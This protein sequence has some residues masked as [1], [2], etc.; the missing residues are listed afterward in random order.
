M[1]TTKED[2]PGLPGE[3]SVPPV[4][5]FASNNRCCLRRD[6]PARRPVFGCVPVCGGVRGSV[7]VERL[8][9]GPEDR[10]PRPGAGRP[11]VPRGRCERRSG[12]YSE[13]APLRAAP[14]R[15]DA[16]AGTD[17]IPHSCFR[18]GKSSGVLF[19]ENLEALWYSQC[20]CPEGRD[21]EPPCAGR[22][23]GKEGC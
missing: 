3:G 1:G 22:R 19:T 5:H 6:K 16:L 23:A 17:L 21:A 11:A 9:V 15:R 13:T 4:P 7:Q 10:D 8:G 12:T 14:R 18:P 2:V 20:W